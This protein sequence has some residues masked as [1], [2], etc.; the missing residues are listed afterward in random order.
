MP[1]EL[2]CLTLDDFP[3]CPEPEPRGLPDVCGSPGYRVLVDPQHLAPMLL[4]IRCGEV[5]RDQLVAPC[6]L[7]TSKHVMDTAESPVS[8]LSDDPDC[9]PLPEPGFA[10]LLAAG[11]LGLLWLARKRG[12][13]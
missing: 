12:D 11:I 8:S 1:A 6:A 10:L 2:P 3:T 13:V 9:L 7:V 4:E 5:V